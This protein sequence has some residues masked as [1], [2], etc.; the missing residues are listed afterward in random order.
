VS[1]GTYVEESAWRV[2]RAGLGY[3]G[4]LGA[5]LGQGVKRYPAANRTGTSSL[6]LSNTGTTGGGTANQFQ[7]AHYVVLFGGPG[8]YKF[9]FS[10]HVTAAMLAGP[11]NLTIRFAIFVT[12]PNRVPVYITGVRDATMTPAGLVETDWT[13]IN[14]PDATGVYIDLLGTFA[15]VPTQWPI[16]GVMSFQFNETQEWGTALTDKTLANFPGSGSHVTN[17]TMLPPIDVVRS[18]P[19]G[20]PSVLIAGDSISCD[21]ANDTTF[22]GYLGYIQRSLAANYPWANIG[23]TG[24]LMRDA[25]VTQKAIRID[26][27][28]GQG[29]THAFI[30]MA[31]NDVGSGL[32]AATIPA[33]QPAISGKEQADPPSTKRK[34]PSTHPCTAPSLR[35]S[36]RSR[37]ARRFSY[38][39]NGGAGTPRLKPMG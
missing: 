20:R 2:S 7:R 38:W 37:I 33:D 16:S 17:F 4:S 30:A 8:Y 31:T 32:T 10:N 15:S 35:A 13:F 25:L 22:A 24:L 1:I 19:T 6:S 36:L 9:R 18:T 14:V 23:G 34:R 11:S 39:A 27:Y 21:G 28:K 26:R 5:V 12:S 29:F 3:S